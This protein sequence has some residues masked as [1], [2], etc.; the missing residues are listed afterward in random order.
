[1]R[2]F[3]VGEVTFHMA[4]ALALFKWLNVSEHVT[5]IRFIITDRLHLYSFL[6]W[7][8][9]GHFASV[10]LFSRSRGLVPPLYF[11]FSCTTHLHVM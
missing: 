5:S 4:G 10:E 6:W 9:P 2:S 3:A 7:G 8:D 1:M 11:S